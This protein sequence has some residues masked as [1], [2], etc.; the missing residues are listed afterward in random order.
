MQNQIKVGVCTVNDQYV[1]AAEI[2][3]RTL[4]F[5]DSSGSRSVGAF[6]ADT[7]QTDEELGDTCSFFS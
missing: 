4:V 7:C 3:R 1:V 5:Y 2:K 6:E